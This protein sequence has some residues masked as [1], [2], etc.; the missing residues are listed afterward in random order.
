M[1]LL[2]A[3]FAVLC[4]GSTAAVA[5]DLADGKKVFAKC[6]ACH[7]VGPT[8]KNK[9]GP[10]L[11]GVLGRPW[12]EIEGYKYSVGKEGTLLAINEAK[13]MTWDLETLT[14]YLRN[15]KAVIPKGKMAFA[16]LKKDEDIENVIFYLA[17][18]DLGG[19]EVDPEAVLSDLEESSN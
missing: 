17:Q 10:I 14:A 5:G 7:D 1:R 19:N 4:A 16:G 9:V 12:G 6:K 3:V 2:V 13:P 11:N 8:A 18:F 15:P